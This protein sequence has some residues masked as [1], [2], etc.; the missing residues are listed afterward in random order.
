MST[1]TVLPTVKVRVLK[2]K[3]TCL[4]VGHQPQDCEYEVKE[5]LLGRDVRCRHCDKRAPQ[6]G[7]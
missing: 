6:I 7:D 5:T 1:A 2:T 4:V 3:G